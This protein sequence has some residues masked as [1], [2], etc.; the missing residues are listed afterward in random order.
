MCCNNGCRGGFFGIG[1]GRMPH[2]MPFMTGNGCGNGCGCGCDNG[3]DYDNEND[4][5]CGRNR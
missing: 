2:D 4:C 3:Y 5:G 1:I